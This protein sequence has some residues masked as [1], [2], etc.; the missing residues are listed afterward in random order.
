MRL[1]YQDISKSRH[2]TLSATL[3]AVL[4]LATPLSALARGALAVGEPKSIA[5]GGFTWGASVNR[6]TSEGAQLHAL[7]TCLTIKGNAPLATRGLCRVVEIFDHKCYAMGWDPKDGTPGVGWAVAATK[8]D[9]EHAALE[10]CHSTAGSRKEFCV[11]S[12][13]D[14]DTTP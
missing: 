8:A 13:S 14:C 5:K 11:I 7:E 1:W 2:V 4:A 12:H 10:R 6:D 3:L 9:A